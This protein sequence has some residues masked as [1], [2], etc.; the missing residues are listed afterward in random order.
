MQPSHTWHRLAALG[1]AALF[2]TG[3][4][5]IKATTLTGWQVACFR[6]GIAAVTLLLLVPSAR[7]NWSWQVPLAG[8]AYATTLVTFVTANK[9]TTSANAIFLQCTGPLYLLLL[10]PL[11]LRER[12]HRGDLAV[13][14]LMS[15]GLGL[16]LFSGQPQWVT[17]PDP[18]R[19]NLIGIITGVAWAFTIVAL[20]RL[21]GNRMDGGAAMAAVFMG[22]IIACLVTLP[23]AL[24]VGPSTINDW[25]TITYLG[26]IQIGLAYL[27]LTYAV[28]QLSAMETSLLLLLEPALNP[29]WAL[30]VHGE[31]P[32]N[33]AILGGVLIFTAT[34]AN[35]FRKT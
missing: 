35:L 15:A 13:M 21:G 18:S 27:L 11:L 19:G 5:A 4:A 6:S 23:L 10:S 16:V 25:F 28:K 29:V 2:S 33:P 20:R 22:N 3:G 14:A 26:I 31:R 30:V 17:A 9:L 8:I 1:A 34:F 7:R 12:I 24:P 32:T